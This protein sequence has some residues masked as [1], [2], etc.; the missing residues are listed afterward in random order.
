MGDI[1]P[2]NIMVNAKK[3]V[4]IIDADSWQLD[5]YPC[6]VGFPQF[7]AASAASKPY[8][9]GLRTMEEELFAVATMLFMVLITGQF[10]YARTGTDGGDFVG[11]IKEGN[12]AFQYKE[13]SNQDQPEGNWKYMWSHLHPDIKAMFWQTFH[14]D[15]DFYRKRPTANEWLAAFRKYRRWL[16]SS[17]NFDPMSNDVYPFRFKARGPDAPISDCVQCKR[18]HAVVGEWN[19]TAQTYSTSTVCF[20][21][22]QL[23]LPRCSDRGTPKAESS[24][25]NGRCRECNRTREYA[26]CAGCGNEIPRKYLVAGRCTKCQLGTCKKC[27]KSVRNAELTFGRC[28]ACDK[29][30]KAL[31]P[32]RRCLDCNAPFIAYDRVDWFKSKG[33]DV[34]KS[35]AAIK[36]AC[37]PP[38]TAPRQRSRPATFA[39]PRTPAPQ[40][41]WVRLMKWFQGN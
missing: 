19:D 13:R 27:Q 12:F 28:S 38:A 34:A 29:N 8:S 25:R 7:T 14:R 24:L 6:P 35:H 18:K 40:G 23:N 10:P 3:D 20:D 31:D 32:L 1:N 21:C 37:P 9:E 5:G 17:K 15:G 2:K 36:R 30:A 39:K 4:W 16:G 11:L 26:N 22:R 41:F 33:L